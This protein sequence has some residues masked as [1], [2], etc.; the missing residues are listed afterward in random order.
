MKQMS[1]LCEI[2]RLVREGSQFFISTHSPILITFP[3]ADV[4]QL[5]S[6]KIEKV[7]YC[8]TEHFQLTKAFL[9]APEK[10]LGYLLEN[11]K[12]PSGR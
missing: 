7:D 12:E 11:E 4:Y 10:M 9:N 1:L 5:S 8:Q 6:Q 3:G 2:D